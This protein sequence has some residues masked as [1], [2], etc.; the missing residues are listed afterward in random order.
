MAFKIFKVLNHAIVFQTLISCP[1]NGTQKF[2]SQ[3]LSHTYTIFQHL[4]QRYIRLHVNAVAMD[5]RMR[6]IPIASVMMI[7]FV[8]N[9]AKLLHLNNLHPLVFGVTCVPRQD[10]ELTLLHDIKQ[11]FIPLGYESKRNQ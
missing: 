3:L 2:C 1:R 11:S 6:V 9:K 8:N 5:Q 10:I 4:V 7:L